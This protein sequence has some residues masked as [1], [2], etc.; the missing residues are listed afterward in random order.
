[1]SFYDS[2]THGMVPVAPL[3]GSE[4]IRYGVRA[5][6]KGLVILETEQQIVVAYPSGCEMTIAKADI[7]ERRPL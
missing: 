4:F 6:T 2:F 7:T 5:W 1:M 3:P